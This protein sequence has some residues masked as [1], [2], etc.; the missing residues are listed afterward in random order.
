MA[1]KVG[2]GGA[3]TLQGRGRPAQTPCNAKGE[4]SLS[5][6]TSLRPP[7]LCVTM[8]RGEVVFT[9][10]CLDWKRQTESRLGTHSSKS[11]QEGQL[12]FQKHLCMEHLWCRGAGSSHW[13]L[14]DPL[15][16]RFFVSTGCK[17]D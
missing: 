15:V 17:G 1:R 8:D 2:P 5:S 11:R 16:T 9:E 6:G 14:Q 7:R 10:F 13:A 4:A 3:V 12:P